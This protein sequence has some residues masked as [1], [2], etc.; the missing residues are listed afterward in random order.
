MTFHVTHVQ[1]SYD[2]QCSRTLPMNVTIESAHCDCDRNSRR[3]GNAME[4]CAYST[5]SQSKKQ[6]LSHQNQAF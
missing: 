1:V 5:K 3:I 4:S 2:S 6:N